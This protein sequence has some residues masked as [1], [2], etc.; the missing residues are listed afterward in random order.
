MGEI[1]ADVSGVEDEGRREERTYLRSEC[2]YIKY[3]MCCGSCG[4][5][6]GADA[7]GESSL[8]LWWPLDRLCGLIRHD[9]SV[10]LR[11]NVTCAIE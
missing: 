8:R 4:S 1:A 5:C 9:Y 7:G 10:E 6:V 2:A 3:G 11:K